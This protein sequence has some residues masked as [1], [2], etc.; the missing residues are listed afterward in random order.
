MLTTTVRRLAPPVLLFLAW[1]PVAHAWTWP[2]N[3][4]VLEPF[5]Y[6]EAHPY[7]AGQHRGIDIGADAAGEPVVA[8]AG[9]TISFAGTVP[10]NGESV[11]IETSDG[12]AVT[13]THLG[14]IVVSK[15]ATVAEGDP[16]GTI[17]PSGTP[18]VDGPYVHLGI[19]V[20]ADPN[21]YVDPLSLLPA[22]TAQSPP[23]EDAAPSPHPGA[24]AGTSAPPATQPA[25][26]PAPAPP[27]SAPLANPRGSTVRSG[28]SDAPR[29]QR[30]RAQQPRTAAR[31]RPSS[32][33]PASRP[34]QTE[35]RVEHRVRPPHRRSSKPKRVSRRPVVETAAPREATVLD[36]DLE[37]TSTGDVTGRGTPSVPL[38][39]VLNGL[40][41]LVALAAALAAAR[42]R[43]R[44]GSQAE[45]LE[46]PRATVEQRHAA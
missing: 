1:A 19:R 24:S 18:E 42:R 31:P 26:A 29:H 37:V 12:Y 17:G 7:A 23:T 22:A 10:T 9:G 41:A 6:D 38:P 34:A 46:L 36:G 16:I 14:S 35:R 11:T 2:A 32:Q 13:L 8:P 45:V 4:P 33:L 27:A 30:G 25:P 28:H 44:P 39:L 3:G 5:A 20:A 15:G 40:A 43:A 21:G